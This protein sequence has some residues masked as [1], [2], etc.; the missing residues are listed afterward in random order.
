MKT[1]ED[2]VSHRPAANAPRSN[3]GTPMSSATS[4]LR[5][6]C[7]CA[8]ISLIGSVAFSQTTRPTTRP[9]APDS[10]TLK[11]LSADQML[12]QMLKPATNPSR[13]LATT[14]DRPTT[15]RS[16]G[17]GAVIPNA[18]TVNLRREDTY[19]IDATARLSRTKDNQPEVTFESD[20]K[21]LRDPPMIILPNQTLAR[22]ED[23]ITAAGRDLKFRI[24]GRITEYRGRNYILLE[25]AAVI[26]DAAQQF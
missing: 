5:V 17:T 4:L 20:G 14:P 1:S 22:M 8:V 2:S 3:S 9:A 25:R 19:I 7:V 21:A 16:S 26:S 15:D 11:S 10:G 24:T 6:L 13:P 12:D 23:S 18:P